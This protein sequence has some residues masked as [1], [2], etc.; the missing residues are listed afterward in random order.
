MVREG[1]RSTARGG[2]GASSRT[3]RAARRAGRAGEARRARSAPAPRRPARP[4]GRR[5]RAPAAHTQCSGLGGA[6][7]TK[8][9]HRGARLLRAW[10]V[11]VHLL[12]HPLPLVLHHHHL[13]EQRQ[14]HV[15]VD[16]LAPAEHAHMRCSSSSG[17]YAAARACARGARGSTVGS[18]HRVG[19]AAP[20]TLRGTARAAW[21]PF[22]A[23]RS[24]R[25]AAACPRPHGARG[26]C[27]CSTHDAAA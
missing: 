21:R 26:R 20:R 5:C 18:V 9:M 1:R 10:R 14:Q 2:R 25:R 15:R 22:A 11:A 23:P 4:P 19:S 16:D 13:V 24:A 3:A 7:S 6:R 17:A 8:R 27:T 12:V